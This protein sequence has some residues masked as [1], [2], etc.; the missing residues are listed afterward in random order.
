MPLSYTTLILTHPTPSLEISGL[1]S[2]IFSYQKLGT[3]GPGTG[4]GH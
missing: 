4:W 2:W 3:H 1:K